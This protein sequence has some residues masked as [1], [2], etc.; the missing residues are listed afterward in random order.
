MNEKSRM[1]FY[2]AKHG[3]RR[4][5]QS[6][7]ASPKLERKAIITESAVVK[8]NPYFTVN[9]PEQR[10]ESNISFLT[11][12]FGITA[13]KPAEA[14]A[15]LAA[16]HRFEQDRGEVMANASDFSGDQA[17]RMRKLTPKPQEYREMNMFSPTSM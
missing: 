14:K 11:N 1:D 17:Q 4:G 5:S 3:K 7:P 16:A 9:K 15:N 6:L 12:L 13:A 8:N 10:T 2:R